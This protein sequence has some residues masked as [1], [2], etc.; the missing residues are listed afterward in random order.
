VRIARIDGKLRSLAA[1]AAGP[2][3]ADLQKSGVF[4]HPCCKFLYMVL[5]IGTTVIMRSVCLCMRIFSKK[6]GV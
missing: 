1:S 2:S 4:L 6:R 5:W 3:E